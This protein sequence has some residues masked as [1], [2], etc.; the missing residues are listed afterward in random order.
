MR[1]AAK[2]LKDKGAGL[3]RE[4]TRLKRKFVWAECR[5]RHVDATLSLIVPKLV[6]KAIPPS[7]PKKRVKLFKQG[8]LNWLILDA[9]RV[10][11]EPT[12]IFDVITSVILALG[13]EEPARP[14]LGSRVRSN[15]HYLVRRCEVAKMG[16]GRDA[17]WKMQQANLPQILEDR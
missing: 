12:R 7:R 13:H 4:V 16:S 15:L 14:A 3:A 1:Y 5:L 17:R 10:P 8:E 2:A 11:G 9:L 6:L